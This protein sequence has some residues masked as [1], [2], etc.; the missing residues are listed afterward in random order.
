M[1]MNGW[2]VDEISGHVRILEPEIG[3]DLPERFIPGDE[4]EAKSQFW[5]RYLVCTY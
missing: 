3:R 4:K 2:D 1:N 5:D